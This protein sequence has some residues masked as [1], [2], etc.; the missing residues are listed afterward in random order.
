VKFLG[1][2]LIA[3]YEDV[4]FICHSLRP[5]L[6]GLHIAACVAGQMVYEVRRRCGHQLALEAPVKVDLVSTVPESATPAAIAYAN[7]VCSTKTIT[8]IVLLMSVGRSVHSSV[9]RPNG[10]Q[11]LS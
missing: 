9:G 2:V 10:F 11:P 6:D 8:H 3:K 7:C 4:H 1:F 5:M